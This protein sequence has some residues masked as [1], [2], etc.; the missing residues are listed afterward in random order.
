[1]DA[2]YAAA[3]PTLYA[4]HWW[5]RTREEIVLGRIRQLLASRSDARILD[6][7]CG[8]GLFFDPLQAFGHVEGLETDVDA[9]MRAGRWQ[10]H[11]THGRLDSSFAPARPFDLVLLL[12]VLEHVERPD[13]VLRRASEILRP[14]GS[15][16]VT[17]PAFEWLWTT[18]DDLN[19]HLRRYTARELRASLARSGFV[20]IDTQYMFQSMVAAK[21]MVRVYERLTGASPEVPRVPSP[22][23][24]GACRAWYRFENRAFGWLPF[25][26]SVMAHG[27]RV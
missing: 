1:V 12:D 18:H 21:L 25:G 9:I 10:R 27:R 24:N 17:V 26:G 16:L 23:V 5:W 13:A 7:G 3:Y 22:T 8:S 4:N 20:A 19:H 2:E 14:G 11:I 6:V 15:V